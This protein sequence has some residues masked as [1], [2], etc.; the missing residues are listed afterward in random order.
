[1]AGPRGVT[2][3]DRE[4]GARLRWARQAIGATRR[5]LGEV[6]GVSGQQI[7][8]YELGRSRISAGQL[9]AV[10]RAFKIPIVRL[11]GEI[12]TDASVERY[13]A[14]IELF[15]NFSSLDEGL[16][17]I[18]TDLAKALASRDDTHQV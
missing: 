12:D 4:I 6:L 15:H 7:L 13:K 3:D 16:Q 11:F 2:S 9:V 8:K 17:K 5:Q 18:V 1:M 10:A 14:N